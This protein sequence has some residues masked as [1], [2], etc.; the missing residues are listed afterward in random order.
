MQLLDQILKRVFRTECI[1]SIHIC[2]YTYVYVR[3]CVYEYMVVC[4]YL[5]CTFFT[6][7]MSCAIFFFIFL[8]IFCM[9]LCTRECVSVCV[10]VCIIKCIYIIHIHMHKRTFVQAEGV[11]C[12]CQCLHVYK[13]VWMCMLYVHRLIKYFLFS[14]SN[15]ILPIVF[16]NLHKNIPYVCMYVCK[17]THIHI[18]GEYECLKSWN[19]FIYLLTFVH[20]FII[21]T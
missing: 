18:R 1:C 12:Q 6:N 17:H 9:Q 8:T 13:H 4:E 16:L 11:Q 15:Y 3:M 19:L 7:A 10:Y 5:H 21:V 14:G 20:L 2:M